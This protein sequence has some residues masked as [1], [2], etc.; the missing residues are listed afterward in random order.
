ML[1]G[2]RDNTGPESFQP[3]TRQCPSARGGCWIFCRKKMSERSELLFQKKSNSHTASP[4]AQ[5]EGWEPKPSRPTKREVR[6]PK[7]DSQKAKLKSAP[8]PRQSLHHRQCRGTP[9]R[10]SGRAASGH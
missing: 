10:V 1:V 9:H 8:Q 6:E 2:R 4:P 7:P 3:R 5:P